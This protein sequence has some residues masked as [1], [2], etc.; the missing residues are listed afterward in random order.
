MFDERGKYGRKSQLL[1]MCLG[2]RILAEL[3]GVDMYETERPITLVVLEFC[4]Q[5][6]WSF[7]IS[8]TGSLTSSFANIRRL[9]YKD[10]AA[11]CAGLL[12]GR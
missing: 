12:S 1:E 4:F 5:K 8:V 2:S 11:D 6:Y 7:T 3:A 9:A 10:P